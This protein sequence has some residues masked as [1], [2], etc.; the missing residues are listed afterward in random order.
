MAFAA[1]K[2]KNNTYTFKYMLSQTYK[3]EFIMDMLK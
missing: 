3:S 2:E 1:N